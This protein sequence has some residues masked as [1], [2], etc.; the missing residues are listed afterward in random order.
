MALG[1]RLRRLSDRVS[2]EAASIYQLYGNEF[3]PRWFPVFYVLTER[4]GQTIT[5][6]AQE[7]GHTHVSV[8]QI[9]KDLAKH[10][11]VEERVASGT[12]RRKNHVYLSEAGK[13]L[14]SRLQPQFADVNDAIEAALAE[15]DHNLW[16]AIAEWE[17]LLEQKSL[18]RRVQEIRKQRESGAVRIVD[19][20][21]E[22]KAAFR[23]LNEEWITRYFRM[24]AA[25]YEALDHPEKKILEPGGFIFVALYEDEPVGVC[26]LMPHPHF[27]W[28]L[29]KMAVSPKA[30]GR[31]IGYLLGR[32]VIEKAKE[33]GA[34]RLYLESNTQLKPAVN[35][36]YKLGF[37]KVT[38]R[39]SPYERAN[40]Q[41]ELAL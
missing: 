24:E 9:V 4:D 7:I 15:T 29:A 38:G 25:D 23:D 22:Y 36:Y 6:I 35:L 31:N 3:Q 11:Y 37:R 27:E 34:G 10:G 12:D 16:A 26:A 2:D 32:R 39:P 1:S 8:S 19:Y 18:F 30:Q 13:A 40:I 5:G 20:K 33:L 14:F 21:P 41:M 17:H 28:E